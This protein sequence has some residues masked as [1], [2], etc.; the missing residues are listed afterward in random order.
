MKA[1]VVAVLVIALAG[2][3]KQQE[4]QA[5]LQQK[6]LEYRDQCLTETGANKDVVIKADNGEFDDNDQKLKCFAK[7]FYQKQG[8][9]ND[10]G[11]LKT[12][13]VEARI[14]AS[15]NKEESLAVI[16]KCEALKGADSC[17]TA[18]VIHKCFF[19]YIRQ[20]AIAAAQAAAAAQGTSGAPPAAAAP[21][22]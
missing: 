22:A 15:A 5:A 13:V 12:D 4:D 6:L 19:A 20:Q 2:L 21:S 3:S 7:C 9:I 10:D 8:Y 17:D 14:P 1:I 11:S 18:Y 16:R